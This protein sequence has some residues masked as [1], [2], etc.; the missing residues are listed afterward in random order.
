MLN[1]VTATN[2]V[3]VDVFEIGNQKNTFSYHTKAISSLIPLKNVYY[4]NFTDDTTL[5][6]TAGQW[7]LT[8]VTVFE[9]TKKLDSVVIM[10]ANN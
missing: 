6:I 1:D 8:I 9:T 2:L 7:S 5:K 4:S 10:T 3:N